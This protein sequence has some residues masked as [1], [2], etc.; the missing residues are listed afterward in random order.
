MPVRYLQSHTI[1]TQ[2]FVSNRLALEEADRESQSTLLMNVI[3][4]V[5]YF[6]VNVAN[7]LTNVENMEMADNDN[8][9]RESSVRKG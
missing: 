2:L 5:W 3:R 6:F 7:A 4:I 8:D 1:R 9:R